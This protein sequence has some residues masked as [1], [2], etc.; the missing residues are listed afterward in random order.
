MKKP[1]HL[2]LLL[3]LSAS[4]VTCKKN[5]KVPEEY[6]PF[7]LVGFKWKQDALYD[8][9]CDCSING[10]LI[11]FVPADPDILK[12]FDDNSGVAVSSAGATR[13]YFKYEVT[14]DDSSKPDG[15]SGVFL[16]IKDYRLLKNGVI[17][18]ARPDTMWSI[19]GFSPTGNFMMF[20]KNIAKSFHNADMQQ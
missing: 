1:Y 13:A 4:L 2:L 7:K 14:K 15:F 5:E 12:F 20:Y 17:Q 16:T 19:N 10:N 9:S 11:N 6:E 3:M 18:Q 8:T